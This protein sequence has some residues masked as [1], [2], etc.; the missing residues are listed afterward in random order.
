MS[1]HYGCGVVLG[2]IKLQQGE[3]E[4]DVI[5]TP[6]QIG[7]GICCATYHE[8]INP[9]THVSSQPGAVGSNRHSHGSG[10]WLRTVK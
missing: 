10:S 6:Q 7:T 4:S 8:Y 9:V 2:R 5:L 3:T 1:E